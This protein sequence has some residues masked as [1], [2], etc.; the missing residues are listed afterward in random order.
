ML[1]NGLESQRV[2][3]DTQFQSS[4]KKCIDNAYMQVNHLFKHYK[5][6]ITVKYGPGDTWEWLIYGTADVILF[7]YTIIWLRQRG[8]TAIGTA[9]WLECS[10]L[11]T[12]EIGGTSWHCGYFEQLRIISLHR[13]LSLCRNSITFGPSY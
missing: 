8:S 5:L 12:L 1:A 2:Q 13:Y 4:P 11:P 7:S 10:H 3:R 9:I 6:D